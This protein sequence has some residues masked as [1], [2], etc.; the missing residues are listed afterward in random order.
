MFRTPGLVRSGVFFW[1]LE[2]DSYREIVGAALFGGAGGALNA[3]LKAIEQKRFSVVEFLAHTSSSAMFGV[4]AYQVGA[5]FHLDPSFLG[6]LSGIA[7]WMGTRCVRIAEL[8]IKQKLG[9]KDE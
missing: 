7:G 4:M 6:A 9:V 3:W 2:M 5:G 8:F 1:N